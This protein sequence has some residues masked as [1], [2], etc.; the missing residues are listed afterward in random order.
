MLTSALIADFIETIDL[1]LE[2]PDRL[3][4]R[5]PLPGTLNHFTLAFSVA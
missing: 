4:P 1:R 3:D 5:R 2:P